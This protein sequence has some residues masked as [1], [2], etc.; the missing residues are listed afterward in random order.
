M[1]K[2]LFLISLCFKFAYFLCSCD[3]T[4]QALV[5]DEDSH[6]AE[7]SSEKCDF[8][9]RELRLE[10]VDFCVQNIT[11]RLPA[12]RK[13]FVTIAKRICTCLIDLMC[14]DRNISV[15]G[16]G[17]F[18]CGGF[19]CP[20]AQS[21]SSSMWL[22]ILCV[23]VGCLV[24]IAIS[25]YVHRKLALHQASEVLHEAAVNNQRA[26][27]NPRDPRFHYWQQAPPV[28]FAARLRNSLIQTFARCRFSIRYIFFRL[29]FRFAVFR[30][31][32]YG[33]RKILH[34]YNMVPY[35]G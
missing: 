17:S 32:H 4:F 35:L 33:R 22:I 5:C 19:T 25:R 13:I 28:P 23:L 12:L 26:F 24:L 6:A 31:S 30:N 29:C 21:V 10:N 34:N 9:I 27:E 3:E 18:D 1:L 11:M 20:H 2:F 14:C 16:C 7:I 8:P 15:L